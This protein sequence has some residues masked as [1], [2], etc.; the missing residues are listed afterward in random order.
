LYIRFL[1]GDTTVYD[2]EAEY[3]VSITSERGFALSTVKGTKIGDFLFGQEI[4]REY[5]KI[6]ILATGDLK[7]DDLVGKNIRI[8][9]TPLRNVV[10]NYSEAIKIEPVNKTSNVILISLRDAVKEKA[11]AIVNNLIKQH[12]A[13]AIADKNLVSKNTAEFINDRIKYITAELSAVEGDAEEFKTRHGL[14]D[15][16]S[17]AKLFLQT[18][19]SSEQGILEANTQKALS[20]YMYDYI[21][22][23]NAAGDLIP[24]NLGLNDVSV[25]NMI[26]EY[27]K[28]VLDRNR[29]LKNSSDKNPVVENLDAQLAGIRKSIKESLFNYQAAL[30]IKI[31]E[32]NRQETGINSKIAT[33]PKYEREYRIIQR[34]QQIKETLYLY[35]LQKR[36]E[37]NIALAVT[38]ANTKVI[39]KAYS[40]GEPVAP[41]RKVIYFTALLLGLIIPIIAFYIID[42]LD[43]KVHG[44]HDVDRTGVPFL[45]DIPVSDSKTKMVV[46][47]GGN[48]SIAE[49]FR[50]LRTNVDFML[51]KTK[52]KGR[53]IFLT[54]TLGKEGKSFIALNLA[55][56]I[57]ISGK[58]V[59]LIGMDVRAPKILE[60][61]EMDAKEGLTNYVS[62][63]SVQL[64]HI[65]LKART[66]ENLDILPSGSIP[67]NPAELLM[68]PRI[69]TMFETVADLYE[70]I[71]VDTAPI[72]MVT[73]TLLVSSYADAFVYVVRA[74][75]L[76]KRLLSVPGDLFK[77]KRLPNMA[78][79]ING[80]DKEKGYGYGYGYGYGGYGYGLEKQRPIWKRLLRIK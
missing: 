24:S 19:T 47:R 16:E 34:Q 1:S 9:V 80:T 63:P 50:L 31:K 72:G 28:L 44:K 57:A 62:D 8:A 3:S 40:N 7:K 67:P 65:I 17:E 75:F 45:G 42:V 46:S 73:D 52:S 68:S 60:Y 77:D 37:T 35:L 5:G 21:V 11:A 13:D 61:L 32:L 51:G 12:N 79:L 14:V 71:I 38:V 39:D 27:N 2:L 6:I 66:V 4:E 58:K 43:N 76:D 15:V 23:H 49:A 54:S 74:Y 22:Q 33:V 69:K 55:A 41:K 25:A 70:Y 53:T 78:I 48:S 18:G 30:E 20:D 26:T 29:I 64:E 56:S 59:L 36:E 10:D